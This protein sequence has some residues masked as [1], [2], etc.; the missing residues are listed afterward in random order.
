MLTLY[1]F[2]AAPNG[3]K[4][5]IMLGELGWAYETRQVNILQGEQFTPEFLAI[6]PNNKIPVLTD[7]EAEGGELSIFESGA[8]LTYLADKSGR[9]LA[10]SG[11]ARYRALEWTFW[12]VGGLG[13]MIGQLFHFGVRTPEKLPPAIAR[14]T[15]E[16]ERL[17]GVLDR[18]LNEA[19]YLA[20]DDYSIADMCTYPW[21]YVA[22]TLTKDILAESIAAKPALSRWIS[23]VG[24]RP[25]V[26]Y[27]IENTHMTT[28]V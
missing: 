28:K 8:I 18:R 11:H 23:A 22:M 2:A 26:K 6:G 25:A 24:E 5:M 13:P 19:E 12:Q 21:V 20:G 3:R 14:F 17:L 1:T 9:F 27:V 16:G 10:P 7:S 15:E 4:I